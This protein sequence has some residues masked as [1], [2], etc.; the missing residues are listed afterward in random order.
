MKIDR[1]TFNIIYSDA[2]KGITS[3]KDEFIRNWSIKLKGIPEISGIIECIGQIWD[4]AHMSG[5]D[6]IIK[7][8]FTQKQFAD[9]FLIS[10]KTVESWCRTQKPQNPPDYAKL[11]LCKELGILDMF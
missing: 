10:I 9:R 3:D 7:S 2:L 6:I 11:L 1:K 8:G 5:K 4:I